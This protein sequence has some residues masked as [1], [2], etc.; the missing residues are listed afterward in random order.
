MH[1]RRSPQNS[2][3]AGWPSTNSAARQPNTK[4]LK[5]SGAPPCISCDPEP[6]AKKTKTQQKHEAAQAANLKGTQHENSVW[7]VE[8][9]GGVEPPGSHRTSG[10]SAGTTN[11]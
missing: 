9:N 11:M 4:I 7:S 8:R 10:A 3:R 1:A 2:R 5:N 6:T